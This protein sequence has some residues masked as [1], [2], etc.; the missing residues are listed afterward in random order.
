MD[1]VANIFMKMLFAT[2]SKFDTWQTPEQATCLVTVYAAEISQ[3]IYFRRDVLC[4]YVNKV[5]NVVIYPA[6]TKSQPKVLLTQQ[7]YL[8]FLSSYKLQLVKINIGAIKTYSLGVGDTIGMT[9]NES[10]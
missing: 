2:N 8:S 3:A 9:N 7:L 6:D 4:E 5:I 1:L 10:I